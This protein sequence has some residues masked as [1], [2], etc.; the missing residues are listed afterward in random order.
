MPAQLIFNFIIFRVPAGLIAKRWLPLQYSE[1]GLVGEIP[2]KDIKIIGE[3]TT[4]EG[5]IKDD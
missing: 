4:S 2:I 3:Y 5:P 1:E